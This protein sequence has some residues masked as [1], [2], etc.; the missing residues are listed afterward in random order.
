MANKLVRSLNR[1]IR[2]EPRN[3][4]SYF[5][6]PDAYGAM[7]GTTHRTVANDPDVKTGMN[8]ISNLIASMTIKQMENQDKGPDRRIVDGISRIVDIAPCKGL[9]KQ[10]WV[11]RIVKNLILY[12]NA[13]VIPTYAEE[14]YLKELIPV[15]NSDVRID[16]NKSPYGIIVNGQSFSHSEFLHF[17]INCGI[18]SY[19]GDGIKIT[20]KDVVEN[21]ATTDALTKEFM[22]NRF[23]P[24]VI[25][26]VDAKHINMANKKGPVNKE[27]GSTVEGKNLAQ[28]YIDQT[29]TGQPFVIPAGLLEVEQIKP[30]SLVDLAVNENVKLS[31]SWI[32]S[33]LGIP[34]FLLGVG[35]FKQAEYNNMISTT[36]MFYAKAIQDE[37]TA[38]VL[39]SP[40]RYFKLNPA[41]LYNY[42]LVQM[43]NLMSRL[44]TMG[45]T[46]GNEVREKVGMDPSDLDGMDDLIALENYIPVE[47]LGNQ[48][49]LK[50]GEDG[51]E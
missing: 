35:D 41:S 40:R 26:K 15:K 51:E 21:L 10:Q 20:A 1:L 22:T 30:M 39:D 3:E 31:K 42:D 23:M 28:K 8:L 18:D 25:I 9:T 48:E 44:R 46:T 4:I 34:T 12:G 13:Y 5:L 19:F 16:E 45:V 29:S 7:C 36:I 49:K 17:K 6:G 27:D 33:I 47:D 11:T 37:L 43:G 50:G 2:G 14:G 32:A 24:S 38:K